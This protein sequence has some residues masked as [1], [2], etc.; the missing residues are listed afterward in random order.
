MQKTPTTV[1][2]SPRVGIY[3]QTIGILVSLVSLLSWVP[4]GFAGD[5]A[6]PPGLSLTAAVDLALRDNP[7]LKSLRAQREALRERPAQARALPNPMF[8]YS[9]MDLADGGTWPDT[10]EKRFM[11]EQEFPGFGK[12]DL[13]EEM[14]RKDAETLSWELESLTRDIVLKVKESFFDLYALQQ[15]IGIT[16]KEDRVLQRMAKIAE[17][18]Y[19]TGERTQQDVLK[20][21]AEITLLKQRLIEL[22]AQENT[23][24]GNLNTLLNRRA[25]APLNLAASPPRT[26]FSETLESLFARAATHR[27]EVQAAQAQIERYELETKLMARESVPDYRLGLEYRDIGD[28][29]D[30]VMFTIG[31]E[32]PVWQSKYRAGVREAEKMKVS[33]QAARE[34]AERNSVR[35][36]QD[37]RFKLQTARRMLELYKTEL[38]PQAEA[39]FNAS[40]T[41]YQTGK[42]DFMDHLESQRF[43]LTIRVMA[44]QAEG[45]IGIQLARL[46]RAV[47]MNLESPQNPGETGK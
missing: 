35:D 6:P 24:K 21:Q 33:S 16:R 17:T 39:R 3:R 30:Q 5:S 36:V 7:E 27:P 18:M 19:S 46:E 38:I 4:V 13:K 43:L 47:G 9:G 29:P 45:N 26:D 1:G 41:G 42:V 37:A 23:L 32:L 8:K 28:S 20:A 12:R 2:R 31:V 15:V 10:S 44:V 11:V 40:E 34:S 14:A 25:D 22:D